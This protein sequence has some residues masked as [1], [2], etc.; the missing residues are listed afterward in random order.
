MNVAASEL[1]A[2]RDFI[3]A[4]Q[5]ITEAKGAYKRDPFEH[6]K[7]CVSDMQALAVAVLRKHGIEPRR[8]DTD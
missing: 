2:H 8:T 7:S 3:E 4:L 6:A 1:E 5:E